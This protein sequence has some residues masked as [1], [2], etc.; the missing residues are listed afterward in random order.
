MM[1]TAFLGYTLPWGQMS[2]WGATVITGFF[3][4]VPVVGESLQEWLLGGYS[5]D[6][7]TL[8][9]FFALHYLLPFVLA[10]LVGLHVWALHHVG[11][12][13]PIGISEKTKEDT[14][15]FHPFYT[16]KDAFAI[17]AFLVI[18]AIFLFYLPDALG[19]ADNYIEA[20]PLKTPAH[21]VPEWY[22]LPFYAILRAVPD[23]LAG[24]LLMLG[25]II[26]LFILPWLDT[27]KVRSM[28]F[29]PIARWFFIFF[30]F[31]CFVL[32]WCGAGTPD[33]IAV[34]F[35]K[36][37][38]ITFYR[39]SQIATVYYF[40]YFLVILPILGLIEK[41]LKRPDSIT[42]AVLGDGKHGETLAP[43]E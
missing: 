35:G 3:G 2:F 22:F 34:P 39:V 37:S 28:R 24:I 32:G 10:G 25:A 8:N 36:N 31:F 14:L 33:D 26:V 38:G 6:N 19:H 21:I 23:K 9:R 30:I 29:R 15:A 5:V 40:A 13:N 12:N 4:A 18:F 1:A 7:A 42:K 17:A 16:V 11:Q 27:H 41:P 20:D 43:A